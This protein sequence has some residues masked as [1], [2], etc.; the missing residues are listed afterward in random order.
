MWDKHFCLYDVVLLVWVE[1]ICKW[2]NWWSELY[3]AP[4]PL[5]MDVTW[6]S[7][8]R[9]LGDLI[10]QAIFFLFETLTHVKWNLT[11][12]FINT[13][14]ANL[15]YDGERFFCLS[16]GAW[17]CCSARRKMHLYIYKM[18]EWCCYQFNEHLYAGQSSFLSV[19]KNNLF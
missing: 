11:A 3:S 6:K 19:Y 1:S 17:Y 2:S 4:W 5:L 8:R 12:R 18:W 15:I 7:I 16:S 9:I 13:P 14:V 10:C